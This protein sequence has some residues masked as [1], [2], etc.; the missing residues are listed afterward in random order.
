MNLCAGSFCVYVPVCSFGG[1]MHRDSFGRF[2]EIGCHLCYNGK[3]DIINLENLPMEY[4]RFGNKIIA[5]ID[6]GE[7]ILT[8]TKARCSEDT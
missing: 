8:T 4:R 6:K 7:E 2:M 3:F 5:R 1:S